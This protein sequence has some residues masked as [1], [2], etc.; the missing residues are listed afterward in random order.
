MRLADC[1]R[2]GGGIG[3]KGETHCHR[4][5]AADREAAQRADCPSCGEF[6]RLNPVTGRCVRCSRTCEGCGH[7]LRFKT[8]TRCRTCRIR[9]ELIAAKSPCSRCGRLGFIRSDNGWCG[10]CS[11]RP[12]PPLPLRPC[13]VCGA[14]ARK[15]GEGICH[16]CW[17]RS[18]T[19]PVTQAVNLMVVLDDAP[20]WLVRFAE[21][22]TERHCAA[23]ACLM[24]SA[25]G[26]LVVDGM[27]THPQALL[28][29]S[30][31]PGRSAGALARTL[32][33][34]LVGEHLAFGLDQETRLALGRR[35]RRVDA[36]PAALRPAVAAFA[37]HLVRSRER[38]RRAG[39]RP[40]AD[41]TIEQTLS[42]VR[43]LAHLITAGRGKQHWSTVDVNDIEA[44]LREQPSNRRRRLHTSRQFFRWARKNKLVLVDPTG[45]LSAMSRPGFTGETLTLAE[46]RLLF[47]RWN[48]EPDVHPHEALVGILALLHAASNVELR[49][50]RVEDY[51]ENRQTLHVGRRRLPT[52]LDPVSVSAVQ[53]CLAHRAS[54]ATHNP[55]L[56]VTTQTKTRSTPASS[57][58]LSHILDAASVTPKR[59]R[60]TRIVNLVITL[61]PKVA[62]EALGMQPEGLVDYLADHVDPGRLADSH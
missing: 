50:L 32:E 29:R 16:R 39:T 28:E 56:I 58:Y 31:R 33:E 35:Q 57:A 54:L 14:L 37:D 40:R 41:R 23:R 38:A 30:R 8:A 46:Q 62:G 12:A 15:K 17:T 3:F 48:T 2:C 27:S 7:V 25:V 36:T 26:C 19:R 22:A 4:C 6:L 20:E 9:D 21:F 51:D 43:D 5:R 11:R 1:V 55:H 18:P 61:D 53:R 60:S 24:V 42:I 49:Q 10:P 45:D 44:F 47:R 59:L 52:P 34:F 13:T